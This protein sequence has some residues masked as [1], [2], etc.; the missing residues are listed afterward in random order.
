MKTALVTGITGQDGAY[1]AQLLLQQGYRVVGGARRTSHHSLGRLERLGVAEEVELVPL[2]LIE[3]TNLMRT[4]ENVQPDEVYN[5]AAQSF[6][7]LSFEFPLYTSDVTGLGALR[8]LEAVRGVNPKIKF[9]QASSS[10]MF[11]K[12]SGSPQAEDTPFNPRSPY[13]IAKAF[14]HQGAV[15][16]REAYDMFVCAGV[17]FNHESPLRGEEFV[18]RKITLAAA[19]IAAGKQ[20]DLNLGNLDARRDWG[21]AGDYVKA[22]WL[23]M[24]QQEPRDYV[25]ATGETHS[26]EDFVE[27]AF[28]EV[29]LDWRDYVVVDSK[30]KRPADVELLCGDAS[31]AKRL[32]GWEPTVRFKDLVELMVSADCRLVEDGKA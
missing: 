27:A 13:G 30:L 1:L 4:I 11:G 10:E 15:L 12:V 18:T 19:R 16:Y 28:L 5:L 20:K 26:V 9:Y 32:L 24:Q 23:M 14:A 17:L 8:L 2:E 21:F 25:V 22:M 29:S 6:V 3:M 31:K 7:G